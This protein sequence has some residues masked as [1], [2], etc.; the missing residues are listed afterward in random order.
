MNVKRLDNVKVAP[1]L[2]EGALKAAAAKKLGLRENAFSIYKIL[3][4]SIDARDKTNVKYVYSLAIETGLGR[5]LP[6]Y[7]PGYGRIA[8]IPKSRPK[9]PPK[10]LIVGAG[11]AGLYAALTLLEA[12]VKP[13]LIDRGGGVD[14]IVFRAEVV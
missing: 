5:G 12:G 7:R 4:K 14:E 2:D 13:V 9:N 1:G 3:R 11:P 10:V 8:D 6:D